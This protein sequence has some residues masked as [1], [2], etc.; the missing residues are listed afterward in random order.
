MKNKCDITILETALDWRET[1]VKTASIRIVS[2]T[3][4]VEDVIAALMSAKDALTADGLSDITV[5]TTDDGEISVIGLRVKTPE[6]TAAWDQRQSDW[7][8]GRVRYDTHEP[9]DEMKARYRAVI[10]TEI[11]ERQI[12]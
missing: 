12:R 8:A 1:S 10:A 3:C 4:S 2:A 6:E 7:K 9:T 5:D 11:A